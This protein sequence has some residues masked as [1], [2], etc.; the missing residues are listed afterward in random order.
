MVSAD[1]LKRG[2]L[3]VVG[4][5]PYASNYT[6]LA[7][8][9]SNGRD[10]PAV[11]KPVEGEMPLWDF[12]PGTL[13]RREVAAFV[14]SEAAGWGLVPPTVLRDGPLGYGA[15]QSYVSHD[16]TVTAFD[17]KATHESDLKRIAL[18]DVLV[19]NADRKA[20]HV[21]L[22]PSRQLWAVDHGVCFHADPKLRTVL[23][24]FV[25]EAIS[26][27]DLRALAALDDALDEEV[28]ILLATLLDE[29]EVD[30]MRSRLRA[31]VQERVYPQPGPGRPYPWPPV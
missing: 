16:P 7:R 14:V 21:L 6:L 4:L 31:L 13:C 24:D 8:I 1:D 2:D 17:L 11:Y 29:A 26:P 23:W 15:V 19:N 9:R 25:G 20:G 5:L 10:E 30:A 18:F 22:D 12:P 28:G 27:S 3:K